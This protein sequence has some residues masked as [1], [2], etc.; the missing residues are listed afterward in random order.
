MDSSK[1]AWSPVIWVVLVIVAWL[2][3]PWLVNWIV[4]TAPKGTIEFGTFGDSFGALTSL[5]TG[6]AFVGLIVT[7]RQQKVQ[8]EMQRQDL[9]LQ[10][11]E[12]KAARDELWPG[13]KAR[14][15]CRTRALSNRCLNRRFLIY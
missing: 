4:T 5:F 8:I 6:L 11:D 10:R 9:K 14:W 7:L 1:R 2:L 3:S 12:M 13:K 15:N